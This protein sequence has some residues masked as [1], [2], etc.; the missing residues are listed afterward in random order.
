M[1]IVDGMCLASELRNTTNLQVALDA[2]I[3]AISVD[4]LHRDLGP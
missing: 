2:A 4:I 1:I 3:R